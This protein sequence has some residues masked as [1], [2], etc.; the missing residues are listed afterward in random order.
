M[1]K[2][3]LVAFSD[4]V[5]VIIITIMA[6]EIQVPHGNTW[7]SLQPLIAVFISYVKP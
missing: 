3:R 1:G 5:M 7:A 2:G 6:L 4:G